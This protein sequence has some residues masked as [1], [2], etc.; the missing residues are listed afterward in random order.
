MMHRNDFH[1]KKYYPRAES[2]EKEWKS[3]I[4]TYHTEI[5]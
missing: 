1:L 2:H 3:S 4:R 5:T